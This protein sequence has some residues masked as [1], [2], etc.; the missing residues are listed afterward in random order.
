MVWRF[1]GVFDKAIK[2]YGIWQ[3]VNLYE[4]KFL[5]NGVVGIDVNI[6]L[7]RLLTDEKVC[8]VKWTSF[9]VFFYLNS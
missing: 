4:N 9:V 8:K 7:P 5:K 1:V 6:L 2:S 3:F